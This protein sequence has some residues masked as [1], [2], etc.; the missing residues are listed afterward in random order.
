MPENA[1]AT[2]AVAATGLAK[3]KGRQTGSLSWNE[4]EGFVAF[5]A[6][7]HADEKVS[8]S[9]EAERLSACEIVTQFN[10]TVQSGEAASVAA[11]GSP[12]SR[13]ARM[14][15]TKSSVMGSKTRPAATLNP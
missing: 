4:I 15:R 5:K 8:A 6:A 7:C 12:R 10:R 3:K 1:P 14:F 13:S 2:A 9:S 11:L